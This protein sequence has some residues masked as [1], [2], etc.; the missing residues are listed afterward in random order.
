MMCKDRYAPTSDAGATEEIKYTK[1]IYI[2]I[3]S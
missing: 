3:P 1:H 2:G